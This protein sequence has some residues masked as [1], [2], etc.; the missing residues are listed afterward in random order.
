YA[1]AL[2][3]RHKILQYQDP[4]TGEWVDGPPPPGMSGDINVRAGGTDVRA[5]GVEAPG[6]TQ[7]R[8]E[9]PGAAQ[10]TPTTTLVRPPNVDPGLWQR[11]LDI[12]HPEDRNNLE[13]ILQLVEILRQ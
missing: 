11:A 2:T 5:G 8:P 1:E 9:T 12:A 4:D 10:P 6:A 7:Q 3:H 13:V